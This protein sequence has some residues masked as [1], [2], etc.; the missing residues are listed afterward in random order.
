PPPL[1][2]QSSVRRRLGSILD[3]RGSPQPSCWRISTNRIVYVFHLGV[4]V[5]SLPKWFQQFLHSP[6]SGWVLASPTPKRTSRVDLSSTLALNVTPTY[7]VAS[8][9]EPVCCSRF[10]PNP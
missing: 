1:T 10:T 3:G 9:S 6:A 2:D 4:K 7:F 5:M 8:Y